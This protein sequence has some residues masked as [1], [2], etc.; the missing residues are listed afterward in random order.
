[1]MEGE[2]VV[3]YC[4]SENETSGKQKIRFAK[5]DIR[6]NASNGKADDV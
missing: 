6:D 1:M 5:F 4:R 2:L 3:A